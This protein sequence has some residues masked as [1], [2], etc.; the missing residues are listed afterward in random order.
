MRHRRGWNGGRRNT[1]G[2]GCL[3]GEDAERRRE[4]AGHRRPGTGR[5]AKRGLP[6]RDRESDRGSATVWSLG[7][8]AFL[9]AVFGGVLALGHAV[10]VRH[11]A[12]GGADLAALAAAD[13]WAGGGTA[14]CARAERVTAAQGIRLVRCVIVGETSDVS[15]ASGGGPFTAEIRARAGPAGPVDPGSP[16]RPDE[17]PAAPS[18]E[19]NGGQADQPLAPV[20]TPRSVPRPG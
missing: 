9:L 19:V 1:D 10:V 6:D 15:V 5:G 16:I 7:A 20:P 2:G 18:A 13:G 4:E 12:A 14:A 3:G 11:R 8:I 17:P